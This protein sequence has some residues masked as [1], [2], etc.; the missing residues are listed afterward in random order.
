MALLTG[1]AIVL[2]NG[3]ASNPAP[4]VQSTKPAW[5]LNPNLNKKVGAIGVAGRT[6]DQRIS[7]QRKLAI[8]RALDELAMQ[9]GV[10]VK[11]AMEKEERVTND[12]ASTSM[13]SKST[14]KT[15][16]SDAITAH[17]E[18]VWQDP[19]TSEIYVWLVLD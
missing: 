18:A 1:S 11:L 13:E 12:Q 5:I 3:C 19:L 4:Q 15:T 8:Q 6:Y 9:Q 17:I 7:T 14:Y 16:S 2:L 10:K